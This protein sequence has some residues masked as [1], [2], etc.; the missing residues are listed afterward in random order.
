MDK[1]RNLLPDLPYAENQVKFYWAKHCRGVKMLHYPPSSESGPK[2]NLSLNVHKTRTAEEGKTIYRLK[3]HCMRLSANAMAH[4]LLKSGDKNTC[5]EILVS[6][7]DGVSRNVYVDKR[8]A[9]ALNFDHLEMFPTFNDNKVK[10]KKTLR[11]EYGKARADW[12]MAEAGKRYAALARARQ[13]QVFA[14]TGK[15]PPLFQWNVGKFD[16]A[17]PLSGSQID[18]WNAL[19]SPVPAGDVFTSHH[20]AFLIPVSYTHLTLPTILRV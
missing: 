4:W 14:T 7:D 17:K 1:L 3:S 10:I 5:Q 18:A 2:T 12:Y 19:Q 9:L 15:K 8:S 13:A 16:E 6:G 11:A 20:P